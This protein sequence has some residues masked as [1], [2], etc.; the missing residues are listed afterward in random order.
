MRARA[1]E[2][3][4]LKSK[5]MP[6]ALFLSLPGAVLLNRMPTAVLEPD[7]YLHTSRHLLRP[8]VRASIVASTACLVAPL[9]PVRLDAPTTSCSSAPI[10]PIK[11]R[12]CTAVLHTCL[13]VKRRKVSPPEKQ[14]LF[15]VLLDQLESTVRTPLVVCDTR[16]GKVHIFRTAFPHHLLHTTATATTPDR[17]LHAACLLDLAVFILHFS[18]TPDFSLQAPGKADSLAASRRPS[19]PKSRQIEPAAHT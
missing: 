16:T 12:R 4:L 6:P 11:R 1:R 14:S 2:S 7:V 8:S 13:K 10:T 19:P 5:K 9:A 18:N 17:V 15:V 3:S